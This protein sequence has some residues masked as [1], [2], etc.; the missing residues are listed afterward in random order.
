MTIPIAS[1]STW[2]LIPFF[3]HLHPLLHPILQEHPFAFFTGLADPRLMST[4]FENEILDGLLVSSTK[5]PAKTLSRTPW[6]L[7]EIRTVLLFVAITLY[8]L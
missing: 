2:H 4:Y 8:L 6:S 3:L 7:S 5:L 1:A